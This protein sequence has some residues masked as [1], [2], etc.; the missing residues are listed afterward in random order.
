[1][2]IIDKKMI[3]MVLMIFMVSCSNNDYPEAPPKKDLISNILEYGDIYSYN[4]LMFYYYRDGLNNFPLAVHMVENY[5]Y[6]RACYDIF[7]M[8]Y[9]TFKNEFIEIDTVTQNLLIYYL[10][11]GISLGD[12]DCA[13]IMSHLYMDGLYVEKDT[14][15]AKKCLMQVFTPIGVDTLFWPIVK[16]RTGQMRYNI[17]K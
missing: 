6:K 5:G 2:T 13:W 17:K 12:T 7:D 15:K 4:Q 11:K 1:M 3:F 10:E 16:K 8:F 9:D 14:I